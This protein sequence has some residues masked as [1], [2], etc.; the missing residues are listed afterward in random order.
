MKEIIVQLRDLEQQYKERRVLLQEDK[1]RASEK[2]RE[3]DAE[4]A[5]LN[6]HFR[7]H[8]KELESLVQEHTQKLLKLKTRKKAFAQRL[9]RIK[10]EEVHAESEYLKKRRELMA[11]QIEHNINIKNQNNGRSKNDSGRES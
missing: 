7:T 10:E 2:N 6:K 1:R 8:S 3:N 5:R 4:I 9:L 11:K